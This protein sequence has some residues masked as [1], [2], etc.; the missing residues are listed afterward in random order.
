VQAPRICA[1]SARP[2]TLPAAT[3]FTVQAWVRTQSALGA[4]ISLVGPAPGITFLSLLTDGSGNLAGSMWGNDNNDYILG[5]TSTAT[6]LRDGRWHLIA[7]TGDGTTTRIYVDGFLDGVGAYTSTRPGF[8]PAT[9]YMG[10]NLLGEVDEVKI[11]NCART[12]AE[13]GDDALTF[14]RAP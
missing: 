1:R 5:G 6:T 10:T 11:Y 12:A 8:D 9:V 4:F 13:I 2:L 7:L 3:N 14:C